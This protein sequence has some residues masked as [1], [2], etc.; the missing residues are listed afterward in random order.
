MLLH[1]LFT[2]SAAGEAMRGY[3]HGGL[4]IDF[5]GQKSPVARWKLIGL[6]LLVLALQILVFGVTS[7]R[8]AVL[9]AGGNAR[10]VG[11]GEQEEVQDHDFEERGV[12]R[13]GPNTVE[14]IEMHDMQEDSAWI[15][16]DE[17][18]ERVERLQRSSNTE[19]RSRHPLESFYTGECLIA[20]LHLTE[21]V[22]IQWQLTGMGS[23]GT[24][25]PA[26]S[27]QAAVVAA[28]AGRTFTNRLN[29]GLQNNE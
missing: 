14:N 27:V 12:L 11:E 13:Q 16:G 17:G 23:E 18:R 15:H 4:L 6:D 1:L 10:N 8:R 28:A 22:R 5:V 21:T 2:P 25:V 26:S 20:N 19:D 9:A 29:R 3:L 24:N 7:E